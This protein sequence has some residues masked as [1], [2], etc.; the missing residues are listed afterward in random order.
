MKGEKEEIQEFI[1]FLKKPDR[2]AK[3]GAKMPTGVLLH[4]PPGKIYSDRQHENVVLARRDQCVNN[5][6]LNP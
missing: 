2:Y 5:S 1:T 3:I 4:G 6:V